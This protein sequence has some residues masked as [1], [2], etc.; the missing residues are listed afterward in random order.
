MKSS[1]G[2]FSL[3]AGAE[4]P[5]GRVLHV[6]AL[7]PPLG[8]MTTYFKGLL[9]SDV[10]D[11]FETHVVRS[12]QTNKYNYRGFKRIVLDILN[13]PLLAGAVLAALVRYRPA[14]VHI[15]TNSGAG[16]LSSSR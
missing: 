12:D 8:G 7:P 13:T 1:D 10:S 5:L 9:E 2:R 3:R 16:Y 6:A 4:K 15:Q 14:I 11:V